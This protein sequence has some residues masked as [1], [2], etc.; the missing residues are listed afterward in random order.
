MNHEE[1]STV[2]FGGSR[3]LGRYD[4]PPM[5]YRLPTL[6]IVGRPN[7]GKST[8]FNR[9]IGQ[10]VAVV[11]DQPGVT[12]DRLYA[13]F[14]HKGQRFRLVDTGGILFSADDPLIEQIRVQAKVAMEEADA[15]LFVVDA[16]EGINPS[17]WDLARELRGLRQPVLLV[18]TKADN[19]DRSAE[20]QE[21]Y[22]LGFGNVFTVS[23]IHGRGVKELLDEATEGLQGADKEPEGEEETKLAIIG[24]PNVGKSSMLNA[25]TGEER[26][27]VSDVP[28]TTRDAIDTP[29]LWKNRKVRLIDTAGIR[30]R[31]KVQGSIE[32]Y[33]VLRATN[34]MERADC[35]LLVVD[36][37]EGLTDGD[38]RV[39]KSSFDLG[40]PLVVAVNK[41]DLQEPPTGDL[42]RD[43]PLKKDF[44]R[45]IR[46]ELPEMGYAPIRFTSASETSGMEGI[47]NAV[48]SSVE[49]WSFRVSTGVLNRLIQDA[50]FERP[51]TRKGRPLKVYYCTQPQ[52]RPPTFILFVN[53]E[54]LVHFS[55]LRYIENRIRKAFPLDGTPI[56]VIARSSKG[57]YDD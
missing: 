14:E 17:D 10:R 45:T 41:W 25:L 7:V 47:M 43:S 39:A 8:L 44:K 6:V 23:G 37:K 3:G 46:N 51:L 19:M 11:Q 1:D 12:R 54:E 4:S 18:A 5:T 36:G 49:N 32:Y 22:S 50:V 24:R 28:G 40:K 15:I 31:G 20:A 53:D 33:M 27:I 30:R 42:G 55:Y 21:F 34:A 56:R 9:I 38:K 2:R 29:I 16:A 52:T 13:E 57:K 48:F 26:A 35:A